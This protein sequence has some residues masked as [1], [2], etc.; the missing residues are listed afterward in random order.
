MLQ[1]IDGGKIGCLAL[2]GV[3]GLQ[4]KIALQAQIARFLHNHGF[5]FDVVMRS[6]DGQWKLLNE[7]VTGSADE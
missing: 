1:Y 2:A 4:G 6:K 3:V 5:A 7:E